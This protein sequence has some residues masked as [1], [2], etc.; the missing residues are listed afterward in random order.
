MYP[1]KHL[2][3]GYMVLIPDYFRGQGHN[4]AQPGVPE[5]LAK[6][7]Q[8]SSLKEDVEKRILPHAKK[9]GAVR[10]AAAGTCWGTYMTLKLT[11]Y[12]VVHVGVSFHPAH[13]G[14]CKVVGEDERALLETAG[15]KPHVQLKKNIIDISV[16]GVRLQGEGACTFK[17]G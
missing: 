4:P 10:F 3:L 11:T 2:N 15:K 12:C 14:I 16:Q 17:G 1:A 9:H 8:W 6:T 7:T 5:F 13:T